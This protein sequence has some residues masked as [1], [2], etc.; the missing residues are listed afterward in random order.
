MAEASDRRAI[1][2]A[3]SFDPFKV[4]ATLQDMTWNGLYG[5]SAW[6]GDEPGSPYGVKRIFSVQ[7]PM[8]RF[9]TD[10]KAAIWRSEPFPPR[11]APAR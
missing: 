4:A 5:A 3:N 6:T 11:P 8:V 7:Q 1:T 9:T 10:G 2:K